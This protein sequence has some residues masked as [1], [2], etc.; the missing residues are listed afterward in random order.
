MPAPW[1]PSSLLISDHSHCSM[2][3][4]PLHPRKSQKQ[5]FEK[6]K[7]WPPQLLSSMSNQRASRAWLQEGKE[8]Y[9][10]CWRCCNIFCR[11]PS[12]CC[13]PHSGH[14]HQHIGAC[15]TKQ[16]LSG[17]AIAAWDSN[18]SKWKGLTLGVLGGVLG[19]AVRLGKGCST[20]SKA[21]I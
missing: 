6:N 1:G 13:C 9:C 8:K 18:D 19:G 14:H 10:R 4:H 7:K 3:R 2:S 20:Y 21:V 5:I 11:C 17:I 15:Q 12:T 16:F